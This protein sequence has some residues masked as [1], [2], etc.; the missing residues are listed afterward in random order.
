M[1][2]FVSSGFYTQLF[3]SVLMVIL[4]A[5][6]VYLTDRHYTVHSWKRNNYSDLYSHWHIVTL[7]GCGLCKI[8]GSVN[9][10]EHG[11]MKGIAHRGSFKALNIFTVNQTC[12]F[13]P[14][15]TRSI[16]MELLV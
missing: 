13:V 14:K 16:I 8:T 2:K 1:W 3:T 4:M 5:F 15:L 7:P 11:N 12:I 10:S 6:F 9:L